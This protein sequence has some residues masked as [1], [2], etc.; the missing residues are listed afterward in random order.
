MRNFDDESDLRCCGVSIGVLSVEVSF[1]VTVVNVL[2]TIMIIS[3][4]GQA[5]ALRSDPHLCGVVLL[6]ALS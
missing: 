5:V 3:F 4:A 2:I 6:T 1:Q